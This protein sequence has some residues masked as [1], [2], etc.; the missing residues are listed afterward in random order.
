MRAFAASSIIIRRHVT[1]LTL[2]TH[3]WHRRR[4]V[5]FLTIS[6]RGRGGARLNRVVTLLSALKHGLVGG[7]VRDERRVSRGIMNE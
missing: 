7:L 2:K 6:N 5:P 1:S 4:R 3:T